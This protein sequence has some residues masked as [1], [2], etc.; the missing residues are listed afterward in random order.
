MLWLRHRLAATALIQPLAWEL[1]Y[2][3]GAALRRQKKKKKKQKPKTK[4]KKLHS[5]WDHLR[6]LHMNHLH[7]GI[8]N[9]DYNTEKYFVILNEKNRIQVI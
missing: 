5:R 6:Y 1:P 7:N 8:F 3:L 4:P 9:N 2:A